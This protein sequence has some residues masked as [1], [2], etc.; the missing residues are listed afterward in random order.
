MT[1]PIFTTAVRPV[2]IQQTSTQANG[3]HGPY[4]AAFTLAIKPRKKKP[5]RN[6]GFAFSKP[7]T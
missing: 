4:S 7:N 1:V 2:K 3:H 6:A 5:K